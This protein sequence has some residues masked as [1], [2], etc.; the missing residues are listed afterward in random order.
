MPHGS[1]RGRRYCRFFWGKSSR[2]GRC[3]RGV[4]ADL[5]LAKAERL[6]WLQDS[7]GHLLTLDKRAIGRTQVAYMQLAT[8]Q[9]NFAMPAGNRRLNDLQRVPIR[10]PNGRRIA[11]QLNGQASQSLCNDYEFGHNLRIDSTQSELSAI[12]GQ[13]KI[14]TIN[15]IPDSRKFN[16]FS[17]SDFRS[18]HGG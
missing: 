15:S 8:A 3:R 16:V 11:G 6:S 13:T 17:Q 1:D 18:K 12:F 14:P 9:H 10:A 2:Q 5:H 7:F 4:K